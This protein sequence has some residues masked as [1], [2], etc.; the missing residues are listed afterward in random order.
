MY[1]KCK[2]I[3]DARKV[4]D[5]IPQRE[6]ITW[7]TIVTGYVQNGLVEKSLK[8]FHQMQREI[9]R[10]NEFTFSSVIKEGVGLRLSKREYRF[11]L[12]FSRRDLIWISLWVVPLFICM[13]NVSFSS[14]H[15]MC[16]TVCLNEM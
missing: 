10:L 1:A 12:V 7:T 9:M 3:E 11:M 15:G 6:E 4:F 8:L 14:K 16:L 13:L 5:I 2:R